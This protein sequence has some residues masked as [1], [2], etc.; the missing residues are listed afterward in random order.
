MGLAGVTFDGIHTAKILLRLAGLF[1]IRLDLYHTSVRELII[2]Y[3][4]GLIL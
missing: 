1:R 3:S 4:I 2:N